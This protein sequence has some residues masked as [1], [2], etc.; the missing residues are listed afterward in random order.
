MLLIAYP[1]WQR[2]P[3]ARTG[4]LLSVICG[5]TMVNCPLYS[6]KIAKTEVVRPNIWGVRPVAKY[7]SV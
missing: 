2:P 6:E 1:L 4:S 7:N 5:D 3:A